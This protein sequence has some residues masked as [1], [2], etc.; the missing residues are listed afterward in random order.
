MVL[1][2]GGVSFKG[3]DNSCVFSGRLRLSAPPSAPPGKGQNMA[4][5]GSKL[6]LKKT[7]GFNAKNAENFEKFSAEDIG[8]GY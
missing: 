8:H 7:V 5:F 1:S 4:V 6:K 2:I 3:W